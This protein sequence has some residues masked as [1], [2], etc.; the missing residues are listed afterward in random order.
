MPLPGS[1]TL[2]LNDARMTRLTSPGDNFVLPVPHPQRYGRVARSE[3]GFILV[4]SVCCKLICD[5]A[6]Q[7]RVYRACCAEE[8]Y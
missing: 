2:V 6:M 4:Y 7:N 8:I 5:Q 3:I 1:S